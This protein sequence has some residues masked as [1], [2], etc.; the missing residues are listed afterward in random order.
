MFERKDAVRVLRGQNTH[1]QCCLSQL[2]NPIIYLSKIFSREV[3]QN[4]F[5]TLEILLTLRLGAVSA[6]RAQ[7]PGKVG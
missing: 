5:Q 7:S 1:S 2:S 6:V 4:V 3:F